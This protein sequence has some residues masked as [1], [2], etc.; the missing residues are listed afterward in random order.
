[1]RYKKNLYEV[2]LL[3]PS[4]DYQFLTFIPAGRILVQNEELYLNYFAVT[5]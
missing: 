5:L 1:M 4:F 3:V 2:H